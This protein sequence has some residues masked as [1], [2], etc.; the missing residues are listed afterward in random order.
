MENC[1]FRSKINVVPIVFDIPTDV[2]DESPETNN[3]SHKEPKP[4]TSD[5]LE[6]VDN[7]SESSNDSVV[8]RKETPRRSKRNS[9]PKRLTDFVYGATENQ[10][11]DGKKQ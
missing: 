7:D 5:Q 10:E 4:T 8:S 6:I 2:E 11:S 1:F 3:D 9:K